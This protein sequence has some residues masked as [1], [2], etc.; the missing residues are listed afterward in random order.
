[1]HERIRSKGLTF[2]EKRRV[3]AWCDR[4]L[5]WT[6][7]KTVKV[8]QKAYRSVE[9]INFSDHKPV[10]SLLEMKTKI[11]DR[12]KRNAVHEEVLRESDKKV[13]DMLPQITLSKSEVSTPI[14]ARFL[15]HSE[16]LVSLW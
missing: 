12:K 7:D 2:S 10:C 3:P 8:E 9:S 5:F 6:R 15:I 13:N 11:V 14:P 4:V 16:T 1:M